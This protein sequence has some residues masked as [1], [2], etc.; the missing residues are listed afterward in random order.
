MTNTTSN[1][2][3]NTDAEQLSEQL[4]S[5]E[6]LAIAKQQDGSMLNGLLAASD[7]EAL[8]WIVQ[9]VQTATEAAYVFIGELCGDDMTDVRSLANH[10][11]SGRLGDFQYGLAD[12]P[13]ANVLTQKT[14][15]HPSRVAHLF[16]KDELLAQMNIESYV[17]VPLA[18]T[19]GHPLGLLVILD[20]KPLDDATAARMK[21]LL[22]GLRPRAESILSHRYLQQQAPSFTETANTDAPEAHVGE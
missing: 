7:S 4:F 22:E 3:P 8:H 10:G 20:T 6:L 5:H 11:V 17:G 21:V 1:T 9:F 19:S 14:C 18:D 12:T 2:T 15:V 13:C 16:A